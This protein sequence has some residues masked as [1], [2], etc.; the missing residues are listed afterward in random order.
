MWCFVSDR[1]FGGR[2]RGGFRGRDDVRF[3]EIK[4]ETD[5]EDQEYQRKREEILKK[6]RE[7]EDDYVAEEIDLSAFGL[8]SGFGNPEKE[9]KEKEEEK[10]TGLCDVQII[11][12]YLQTARILIQR[13]PFFWGGDS[14]PEM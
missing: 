13:A 1:D 12:T 5:E 2:D 4:D 14:C 7:G 11:S 10:G 3:Q 6:R 9:K 8:P